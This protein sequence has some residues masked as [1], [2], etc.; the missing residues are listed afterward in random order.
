VECRRAVVAATH[1]AALNGTD[2]LYAL[3]EELR[4]AGGRGT[5][6]ATADDAIREIERDLKPLVVP[7]VQ[8]RR[9]SAT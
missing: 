9:M 6:G 5:R 4:A 1:G 2:R 8:S 3:T 7:A